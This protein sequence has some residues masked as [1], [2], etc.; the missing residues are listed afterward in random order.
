MIR[1]IVV[2]DHPLMSEG[3]V[4][5]AAEELGWSVV[6]VAANRRG[7]IELVRRVLVHVEKRTTDR[8]PEP[9]RLAVAAYTDE[10]RYAREVAGL[11]RGQP[12]AVGHTSQLA[13][14]G[15]VMD[16]QQ[17]AAH[18]AGLFRG[19]IPTRE[20]ARR[21]GA[22]AVEDASPAGAARTAPSR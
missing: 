17:A 12:V 2:D 6:G 20:G 11:F 5:L 15:G 21:V 9:S 4:R 19:S 7:A 8:G 14:P 10:Q 16:G 22:A 18:R 3:L 13:A 1:A